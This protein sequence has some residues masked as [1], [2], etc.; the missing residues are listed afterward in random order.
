MLGGAGARLATL[1]ARLQWSGLHLPRWW[2]L[3]HQQPKL[4]ATMIGSAW[5]ALQQWSGLHQ[6]LWVGLHLH[7][8]SEAVEARCCITTTTAHAAAGA[9]APSSEAV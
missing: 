4:P 7:L 1:A 3:T 9:A 8:A 5:L 2:G 6:E